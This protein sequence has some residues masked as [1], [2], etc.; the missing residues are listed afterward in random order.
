MKSGIVTI[1]GRPSAGKSTFVNTACGEKVS[2]VSAVPQ[3][4]RN[5]IRGIV[6][7]SKG[8]IVFI[9]TPGYHSSQK[10]LNL[11]LQEIVKS[12]LEEADAILYLVDISRDFGEEE[13]LICSMLENF[14]S[15]LV[16]GLNKSDKAKEKANAIAQ[17]ISALLPDVQINKILLVS[18]I[19]DTGIN[20]ILLK[21]IELLPEGEQL[22]PT[23]FYTDQDVIFRITEIIREQAI[24]HT[25]EEIPHAVYAKV[26]DTQMRKN[27][28]ELFVRAFLF[29][30]RESQKGMVIGSKASVIKSIRIKAMEEMRKIFPYKVQLNLQVKVKKNWRQNENIIKTITEC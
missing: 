12:R 15:K 7:T 21:F 8:Q 20:E 2:I 10:K 18:A 13:Q 28:K 11:K 16:I 1:I 22:Y 23:E 5:A 29:V 17:K 4:T 25:R 27:G 6:N 3:T 26:E 30:E 19:N 9:D 14:Q 24:L